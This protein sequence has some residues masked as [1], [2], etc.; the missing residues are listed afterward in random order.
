MRTPHAVVVRLHRQLPRH[1]AREEVAYSVARIVLDGLP[2]PR[3]YLLPEPI[4]VRLSR[5]AMVWALHRLIPDALVA[6]AEREEWEPWQLAEAA[7]VS[8]AAAAL[9]ME[10]WQRRC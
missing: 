7:E 6:Q 9:R 1:L 4:K 5:R 2:E 3:D 8:D 10:L